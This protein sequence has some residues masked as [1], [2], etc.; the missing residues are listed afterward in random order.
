MDPIEPPWLAIKE[1]IPDDEPNLDWFNRPRNPSN[2]DGFDQ[3]PGWQPAELLAAA[4]VFPHP[5]FPRPPVRPNGCFSSPRQKLLDS[6]S[7]LEPPRQKHRISTS[8]FVRLKTLAILVEQRSNSSRSENN[9]MQTGFFFIRNHAADPQRISSSSRHLKP[10][11]PS[12]SQGSGAAAFAV[13][14]IGSIFL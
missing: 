8:R 9:A 13:F 14:Q 5:P 10:H 3:R 6:K 4:P 1:W 7:L 11:Q 2:P 12:S